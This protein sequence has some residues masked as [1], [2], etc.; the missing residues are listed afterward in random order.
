MSAPFLQ[1][2]GTGPDIVLLHGWGLH[3]DIWLD[4]A[5]QLATTHRVTLVDL[6]GHGR[7]DGIDAFTLDAVTEAVLANVPAPAAWMGWSL[8]G[9]IALNAAVHSPGAIERLIL[10]ASVPRF[11]RDSGWRH[12]MTPEILASFAAALERDYSATIDQFLAL[13]VMGCDNERVLLRDLRR[14]MRAQPQPQPQALRGGLDI[15]RHA[16][17]RPQLGQIRC[18]LQLIFGERDRLVMP[19]AAD[20]MLYLIQA[21]ARL[22]IIP[23]AGH[24]PFLSHPHAFMNILDNFLTT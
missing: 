19:Q 7:S 1:T 4:T 10:V 2:M 24:A 5:A 22:D 15:L 12:A 8:G 16:D 14:R 18:P 9:M 13:Q 11:V 3:G 20:D 21:Q 6:P 17:L 23:G